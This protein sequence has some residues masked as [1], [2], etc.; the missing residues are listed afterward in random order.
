MESLFA[1]LALLPDGWRENV[2]IDLAADGTIAHVETGSMAG[3]DESVGML[4]PGFCNVHSHAFQRALAGRAEVAGEK[5]DSFWTWRSLMYRLAD[6]LDPEDLR[7]IARLLY[8]EMLEAGYTA[9]GEFHYLHHD[10]A[11]ELYEEPLAMSLALAHAA[12]EAGISLAMLPVLYRYSDFGERPPEP[13]QRRFAMSPEQFVEMVHRLRDRLDD[14]VVGLAFHSL[15]AVDVSSM[16]EVIDA[17]GRPRGY[18]VHIH[19]AEQPR[20]VDACMQLSG[21][22][23]AEMLLLE[24]LPDE[25]WCLI[26]ATHVSE[27]ELKGIAASGAIVGLCPTT[28]AN[29]GDGIF[30]LRSFLEHEGRFA[31]GSDS[32]VSIDPF[33]EFRWLEYGQRLQSGRRL[34][35]VAG[36]GRHA[37]F[38]LVQPAAM[39]GGAALGLNAGRIESGQRA[40]LLVLDPDP[41]LLDTF[42]HEKILDALVF[43]PR[44][45]PVEGVMVDGRWVLRQGRHPL[46]DLALAEY[47][48]CQ[49][50]LRLD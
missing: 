50:R 5:H 37:G 2:H 18:P 20:E 19:V 25:H 13:A 24:D 23:P 33:E 9:V 4:M 49:E 34:R 47:R 17:L 42:G 27:S 31:I 10:P 26:H 6:R 46:R 15:R 14:C 28:E 30:P 48:A 39:Y 43:A 1:R 22:R 12:A 8:V 16:R 29:L 36:A 44:P 40:N 3:A 32:H 21:R 41:S 35:A 38:E 7:S 45:G 11:G